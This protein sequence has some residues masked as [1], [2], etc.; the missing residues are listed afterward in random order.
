[1]SLFPLQHHHWRSLKRGR[2]WLWLGGWRRR[3]PK[4]P[5]IEMCLQPV[6]WHP[7]PKPP[8]LQWTRRWLRRR[9]G[10]RRRKGIEPRP[11]L[12]LL[13]LPLLCWWW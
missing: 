3:M 11:K 13:L 5:Q 1:M 8:Q 4:H 9:R 12:P 6:H 2:V 7:P 10:R